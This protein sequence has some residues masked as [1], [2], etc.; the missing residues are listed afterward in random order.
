MTIGQKIKTQ[1]EALSMTQEELG[2]LCGTTKQTIFK[3]ETGVIT[4]IPMDRLCV[5]AEKLRVSP[6]WILGWDEA[7][8]PEPQPLTSSEASLLSDF[9]QLSGDGQEKLLDYA[10][11]L[12]ASGRYKKAAR[13]DRS[14]SVAKDA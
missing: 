6:C 13:S 3:Y 14:G 5:I 7:S 11:D 9:R 1:R 2:K 12:V 4:N 10:S 8:A